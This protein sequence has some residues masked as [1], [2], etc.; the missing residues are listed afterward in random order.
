[1][2]SLAVAAAL[3]CAAPALAEGPAMQ[4]ACVATAAG[5][6]G[7]AVTVFIHV[8]PDGS[9]AASYA[10]WAP[11]LL[12][13]TGSGGLD[14]PDTTLMI[15][16]DAVSKDSLGQPNLSAQV[17]VM[18]FS[19]LR[20]RIPSAKLQ[21]GLANLSGE[22]RFDGNATL[23]FGFNQPGPAHRDLPGT[24]YRTAQLALPGS[25]PGEIELRLIEKRRKPVVTLRFA[26]GGAAS[27]DA[28]FSKAWAEADAKA[29]TPSKCDPTGG[30]DGY[31]GAASD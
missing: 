18:L 15:G 13:A 11:P 1:M 6:H 24:A 29:A 22:A 30:G 2:R 9:R 23:P 4:M 28:L 12:A 5:P 8:Q 19:P 21:A 25:L 14:Q 3:A 17:M 27:R 16:Y 7:E 31:A 10:S 26:T 20:Q